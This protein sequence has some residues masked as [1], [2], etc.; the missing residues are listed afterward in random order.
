MESLIHLIGMFFMSLVNDPQPLNP[1]KIVEAK[2]SYEVICEIQHLPQDT[3]V[4]CDIDDTVITP[5]SKTFRAA[6]YYKLIDN[7]KRNKHLYQNHAEIVSNWR[8][9]RKV[10]L[11]DKEWPRSLQKLKERFPVY[12]LTKME[13]GRYGNIA[14]VENWR[15]LELKS[16][17]I[18]FTKNEDLQN[19]KIVADG[20]NNPVFY[21]GLFLTGDVSKSQ[22]LD[23]YK[24]ML[25]K[26]ST[27][28][29]IDDRLDYLQD[30]E[31]FCKK[32]SITFIG[33][34]FK[35]VEALRDQPDPQIAAFQEDYLMKHATWLE[36]EDALKLIKCQQVTLKVF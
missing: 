19:Q 2:S 10:M 18:E 1:S 35:G 16:M 14:S 32:E 11:L 23:L 29:M 33:I 8:L 24:S 25:G 3:I 9:Q 20:P 13:T 4:F 28:V 5:V 6:P 17:G 30:I 36:D 26:R 22:V 7:I 27:I 15:Y 31:A 34:L 12:G 21:Q